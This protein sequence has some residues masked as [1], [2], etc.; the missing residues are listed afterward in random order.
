MAER[1]FRDL[2]PDFLQPVRPP[3]VLRADQRQVRANP[4]AR[5]RPPCCARKAGLHIGV[6]SIR[7]SQ[8]LLQPRPAA[9]GR[10][11]PRRRRRRVDEIDQP[12]VAESRTAISGCAIWKPPSRQANQVVAKVCEV[13]ID[14]A[15]HPPRRSSAKAAS[16][17]SKARVRPGR[18]PRP[19]SVS[20]TRP[21]P[22]ANKRHAKPFF[23][24]A[25]LIADGGLGHPELGRGLGEILAAGRGLEDA[26]GA[27][28]RK[29][30]ACR[31]AISAAYATC[32]AFRWRKDPRNVISTASPR[33][34]T[35]PRIQGKEFDMRDDFLTR[36]SGPIII[37]QLLQRHRASA[38]RAPRRDRPILAV[39]RDHAS[40]ARAGA[41]V[42]DHRPH[43]QHHRNL[44]NSTCPAPRIPAAHS[45]VSWRKSAF[46]CAS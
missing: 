13:E 8:C 39:G 35:D 17:A 28:G 11:G 33:G 45:G 10:R 31:K 41:V 24:Q 23:Q 29:A 46:R 4:P 2:D 40:A 14:R 1:A 38:R 12:V 36:R 16:S 7:N 42:R 34:Q 5:S 20:A 6:K 43:L 21:L 26:D 30:G 22:R 27:E 18:N 19:A 3:Y 44:R 15:P 25:D 37:E 32:R 9:C